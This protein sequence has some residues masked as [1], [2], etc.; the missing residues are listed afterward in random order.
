M[1]AHDPPRRGM[2]EY[3]NISP[4]SSAPSAEKITG[5]PSKNRGPCCRK[6]GKPLRLEPLG[7]GQPSVDAMNLSVGR[8]FCQTCLF[9]R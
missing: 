2:L 9:A 7:F 4:T 6:C 3:L 8:P 1:A 5:I